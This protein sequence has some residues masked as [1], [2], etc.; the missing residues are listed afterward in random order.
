MFHVIIEAK[1]F[2]GRRR[3]KGI[4]IAEEREN[5]ENVIHERGLHASNIL[6]MQSP[7]KE[8]IA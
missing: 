7:Q 5:G 8:K 3:V 4:R 1:E 6:Y 2:C